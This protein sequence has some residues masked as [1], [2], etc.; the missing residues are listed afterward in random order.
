MTPA[1]IRLLRL[2]CEHFHDTMDPSNFEHLC[3]MIG[4]QVFEGLDPSDLWRPGTF[5]VRMIRKEFHKIYEFFVEKKKPEILRSQ[6]KESFAHYCGFLRLLNVLKQYSKMHKIWKFSAFFSYLLFEYCPFYCTM[7]N[8]H[9][10]WVIDAVQKDNLTK[11]ASGIVPNGPG[12]GT[13]LY[14]LYI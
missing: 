7:R 11:V 3:A 13:P 9:C 1:K 4:W 8:D 6:F 14:W 2:L 12:G 5:G 10:T